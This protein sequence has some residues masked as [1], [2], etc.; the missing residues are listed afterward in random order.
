VTALRFYF[1]Y[2]SP[3]AYLAWKQIQGVADRH[4]RELEPVPVLFA[5][6]L[7]AHQTRGPAEIPARR[8]YLYRDITRTARRIGVALEPP[9]AHPFNPLVALRVSSLPLLPGQRLALIEGLFAAT[10][11]GGGGITD[12]A[13]IARIA[14]A[15]GLPG[16]ALVAQAATAEA[17]DLV[18]RHTEEAIAAGA[19]GVP[20]I[21]VDGELFWGHDSLPN[22][23]AFLGGEAAMD[24]ALI[25]RW[26]HLPVQ[27]SRKLP[28]A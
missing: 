15:A 3:Y 27:A 12:P 5:G 8:R 14:S 21:L 9:P 6:L 7:A 16:D 28:P 23:E 4:R 24:P 25:A 19:F 2:I 26:E 18:R 13:Q 1:D 20:T 22:L 17:K 10:W 11:A